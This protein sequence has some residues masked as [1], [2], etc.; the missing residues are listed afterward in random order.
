M[1]LFG[2]GKEAAPNG[3]KMRLPSEDDPVHLLSENNCVV[4]KLGVRLLR[5]ATAI[6]GGSRRTLESAFGKEPLFTV[7]T[8]YVALCRFSLYSTFPHLISIFIGHPNLLVPSEHLYRLLREQ[9]LAQTGKTKK[10]RCHIKGG[11]DQ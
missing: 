7:L 3:Q 9:M 1:G 11:R 5:V 2:C 10:S 4:A 8:L 6:S